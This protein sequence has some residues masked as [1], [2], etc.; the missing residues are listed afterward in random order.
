[1]G[2]AMIAHVAEASEGSGR[3]L[4]W[5]EPRAL[6]GE[7][8]IEGA[9]RLAAAFGSEIETLVVDD[10]AL[11]R[12]LELPVSR[13]FGLSRTDQFQDWAHEAGNALALLGDRQRREIEKYAGTFGVPCHHTITVGDPIDQLTGLCLMAGPWNVI[14]LS[15]EPSVA[16]ATTISAIMANVSGA[17]GVVVAGR[18]PKRSADRIAVVIEDPER[19]PSM[20]RVAE[21]LR[22]KGGMIH[23][24][25]AAETLS[26]L[27]ELEA[28]AR[29]VV[30]DGEGLVFET[31]A[32]T[33]GLE[34]T[35]DERLRKL[36]PGYVIA[37]FGGTLLPSARALARTVSLTAAPFLLVR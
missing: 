26:A 32:P 1:M 19:F 2:A 4:F 28:Y 6:V 3:V 33:L 36:A 21:R 37:R 10:G 30:A 31:V 12:A 15:Q 11:S 18:G 5:L 9:T 34:H 29:L 16:T 24:F 25:L 35:F 22:P 23:L 14:A 7:S 20:V 27:S 8:A 13:A 17:T